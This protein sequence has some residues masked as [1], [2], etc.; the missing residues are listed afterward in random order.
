ML[1]CRHS[2]LYGDVSKSILFYKCSFISFAY[3][4]MKLNTELG[5]CQRNASESVFSFPW[6]HMKLDIFPA[7]LGLDGKE[8]ISANPQI[9]SQNWGGGQIQVLRY[10]VCPVRHVFPRGSVVLVGGGYIQL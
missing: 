8:P 7:E 4:Y 1:F 3:T 10:I 6:S 5:L 9:N 2:G